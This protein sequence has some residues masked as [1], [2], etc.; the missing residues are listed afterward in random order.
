MAATPARP[1]VWDTGAADVMLADA[2]EGVRGDVMR[3][4][5]DFPAWGVLALDRLWVAVRGTSLR[6]EAASADGL[7]AALLAAAADDPNG[8][9]AS[10]TTRPDTAGQ[11]PAGVRGYPPA[12]TGVWANLGVLPAETRPGR[13]RRSRRRSSRGNA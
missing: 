6:V 1:D 5:G 2:E 4:R 13:R 8:V 11:I 10:A 7:R 9:P 3:L 12:R